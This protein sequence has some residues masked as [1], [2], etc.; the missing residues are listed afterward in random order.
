[1]TARARR[2]LA[3]L[4]LTWGL[5]IVGLG[6]APVMA[7]GLG[8]GTGGDDK[9]IEVFADQGIE[10]HQNESTYIAR[11]NA[12]AVRG[13][14]TVYGDTLVA[15]YRKAASGSTEVWRLEA[16]GHV[17]IVTPT[18]TAYGD[19]AVYTIDNGVL[20]M[21]GKN[22]RLDTP[23]E[24]ITARDSLEYW[25]EKNLAVARGDAVVVTDDR[26][27]RADVLTAQF[28]PDKT[29]AGAKTASTKTASAKTAA[30]K[31]AAPA[32]TD[33]KEGAKGSAK[34]SRNGEVSRL[35]RIDAYGNVIIT[36]PEEVARG[37]RG[38]YMAET[39]IANLIGSVK[40]T[41]GENQLNGEAAEVNLRTGVSRIV[42]AKNGKA[43]GPVRALIVPERK[44]Q[45]GAPA[46]AP[47]N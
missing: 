2:L 29:R 42:S 22:L 3:A 9:P 37:D 20:V 46:A 39:G 43:G 27:I 7:Q 8:L 12:R 38:V 28:K 36:T 17:R 30:T 24:K 5:L 14:T 26:R 40:I 21:T 10:W 4:T 31:T 23:R 19:R 25:N 35:N 16:N 34:D 33:A 41:R 44:D 6:A 45:D 47:R 18:D 15:H 13:D 32:T 1:V 11:G